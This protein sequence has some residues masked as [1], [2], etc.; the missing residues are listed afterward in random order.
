MAA[1]LFERTSTEGI[2]FDTPG[3]VMAGI[4]AREVA[5]QNKLFQ[6]TQLRLR[7]A[8]QI[9]ARGAEE[10]ARQAAKAERERVRTATD[11]IGAIA[12]SAANLD[13]N[14]MDDTVVSGILSQDPDFQK[15]DPKAQAD[16]IRQYKI[17]NAAK[18]TDSRV[19]QDYLEKAANRSKQPL[20]DNEHRRS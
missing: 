7:E 19:F 9:W 2:K 16:A 10:R 12:D 6:D 13:A 18:I 3:E 11:R 4:Q 14:R 8:D 17:D 20:P 5:K 15:M 1:K